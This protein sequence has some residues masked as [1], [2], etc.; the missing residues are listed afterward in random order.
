M[1]K[2]TPFTKDFFFDGKLTVY[3]PE[4]GYRFSVDAV[5]LADFS[6]ERLPGNHK[7]EK[8]KEEQQKEKQA[9]PVRILELCAG[10]GIV[11]LIL[12][13][14]KPCLKIE[15]VE[16]QDNLYQIFERNISE[17]GFQKQILAIQKDLKSLT[18]KDITHPA[19]MVVVNPP[20]RKIRSGRINP[21]T[22]K[23]I[24]RHEI[25]ADLRDVLQC[26]VRFLPISG[27]FTMV[28]PASRMPYAL[29]LMSEFGLEPKYIRMVYAQKDRE[30]SLFLVEGVRKAS[31]G[32]LVGP[33][34]FMYDEKGDSTPALL[35]VLGKA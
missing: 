9:H 22:E 3:Q 18:G 25:L 26:A 7:G 2:A 32:A 33:P 34:F 27:R 6:M 28:Y 29:K 14:R 19:D 1:N 20:F 24:A 31:P 13:F 11:S 17:N 12:A 10:C 23:A 8:G 5:L 21:H 16:I 35:S 15:G 30:A 4:K